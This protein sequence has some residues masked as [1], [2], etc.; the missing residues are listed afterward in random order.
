MDTQTC[1]LSSNEPIEVYSNGVKSI[2]AD[3]VMQR[4]APYLKE[5]NEP[6]GPVES[7]TNQLFIF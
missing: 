6:Q 3:R 5:T 4:W 1:V 2:V 7:F